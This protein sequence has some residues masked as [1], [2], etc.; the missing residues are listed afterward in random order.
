MNKAVTHR[1]SAFLCL[2]LLLP[3]LPPLQAEIFRWVDKQGQVHF[4]DAE[5]KPEHVEQA[6]QVTVE[7]NVVK[8]RPG[9]NPGSQRSQQANTRNNSKR[10]K[11][12]PSQLT[13]IEQTRAKCVAAKENLEKVR[14]QMRVGY[15]AKQYRRLHEREIRYME[16]RQHYCH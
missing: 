5:N 6:E 3:I 9:L 1:N 13:I 16:Q 7:P 12:N 2:I 11:K 8:V 4:S 14:Q 15:T 10:L